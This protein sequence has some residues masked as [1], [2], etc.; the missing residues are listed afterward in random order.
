MSLNLMGL[1]IIRVVMHHIPKRQDGRLP[2]T[3]SYGE[4]LI[5][6]SPRAKDAFQL[7]IT[8]ALSRR[9]HGIEV[10][11]VDSDEHSYFQ[12]GARIL[13]TNDL[14]FLSLSKALAD[15]LAQKQANRD[16]AASKLI[17]VQGIAGQNSSKFLAAIKADLQDG[18][19]D[20]RDR[21]VTHL[22]NLFLTPSQRLYK[23]GFLL[24]VVASA[25]NQDSLYDER[26]YK[27]YLYDHLLTALETR[28]AA[29][30]FYRDF[31]GADILQSDKKLT[32]DF[33]DL[34]T[35]FIN[36]APVDQE[37]KVE[38]LDA[39]RTELRSNRGLIN[40]RNF[41]VVNLDPELQQQYLDFLS[42]KGLAAEMRCPH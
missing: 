19:T 2:A 18:F 39:L 7:R 5:E 6:L 3:P 36:G 33:Y 30:Y 17:I 32:R 23:I 22:E 16:L 20:D 8:E 41:A 15:R 27:L 29:Y 24:E 12:V 40:T 38:L 13:N 21:G 42:Q 11:I 34:S 31:L 26:N 37:R 14:D 35:A 28:K 25:P 9:S 4:Q 1:E 10:A